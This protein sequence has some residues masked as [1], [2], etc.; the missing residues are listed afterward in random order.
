MLWYILMG[1]GIILA[2]QGFRLYVPVLDDICFSISK[3][4]IYGGVVLAILPFLLGLVFTDVNTTDYTISD[5]PVLKRTTEITSLG[6]L[7]SV[8]YFYFIKKTDKGKITDKIPQKNSYI[9]ED[10]S[11][12]PRIEEYAYK[13]ERNATKDFWLSMTF[14]KDKD[15]FIYNTAYFRVFIPE[16][17]LKRDFSVNLK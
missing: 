12:N 5:E 3:C 8:D 14:G 9:T 6:D 4:F 10:N 13:S 16:N 11:Q 15:D 17:S 1:I 7:G 2:I